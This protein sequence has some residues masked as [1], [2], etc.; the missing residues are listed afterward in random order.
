MT[1]AQIGTVEAP[2]DTTKKLIELIKAK[3]KGFF[4][5]GLPGISE[6]EILTEDATQRTIFIQNAVPFLTG[7]ARSTEVRAAAV[8]LQ[9]RSG[10]SYGRDHS[11]PGL[12]GFSAGQSDGSGDLL[13]D[14]LTNAAARDGK[15]QDLLTGPL[16]E[17]LP[18]FAT[19]TDASA[20]WNQ[21]DR[22]VG[23]WDGSVLERYWRNIAAQLPI[24][25]Q[26]EKIDLMNAGIVANFLMGLPAAPYPY[27]VDIAKAAKGEVLLA[28]NCGTC[29]RPRNDRRYPEVNTD[30]NRAQVLNPAGSAIFLAAF[31]AACHDPNFS[32]VDTYGRHLQPCAMPD[33]RI[34]RDTTETANQGYLAPPLDGIWARAPYLH[35]GSI[36]TLAHV[37]QPNNRPETF[38]RGVIAFDPILV[39]WAWETASQKRYAAKYPTVSV[40]DTRRDGWSNRGHDRNIVIDGK[41]HRLDWSDPA[42]AEDFDALLEYLK[43]L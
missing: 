6:A 30:M 9:L 41:L 36:P 18:R 35:N 27:D 43:T 19:V 21:G 31:K 12:A 2:G 15:L 11:S 3:P 8:A 14:L 38:L 28:E 29:H 17:A 33:Y 16:P 4:S 20:V 39:G 10:S 42:L 7:L 26:P 37:L 24:V 1:D 40:H 22:S 25:G 34:L 5:R 13:A 32:Y 23:Q